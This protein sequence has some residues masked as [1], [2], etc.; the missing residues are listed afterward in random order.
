MLQRPDIWGD[1]AEEFNPDHW[2]PEKVNERHSFCFLPFSGGP[3][4]C[5]GYI[6][7]MM[8]MKVVLS[9]I[10]RKYKFHTNLKLNELEMK[11]E[12]TLKLSN[13]HMVGM[14]RRVW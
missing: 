10:L 2:L 12:L 4:N 3:R 11:F 7:A 13:K 6:Y 1:D 14:E 5:I 9:G 8:S